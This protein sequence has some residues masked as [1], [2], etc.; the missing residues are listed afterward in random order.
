MN[1]K[2][3]LRPYGEQKRKFHHVVSQANT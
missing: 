1:E 3:M 2:M